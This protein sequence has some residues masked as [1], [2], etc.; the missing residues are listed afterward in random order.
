M[1]DKMVV[2]K[3][4]SQSSEANMLASLL[5][6]EGIECYVRDTIANQIFGDIDFVEVKIEL[7]EKDLPRA[8][9]IMK[10][11][12]YALS[13]NHPDNISVD[14]SEEEKTDAMAETDAMADDFEDMETA[15]AELIAYQKF[16]NRQVRMLS[17]I[18]ILLIIVGALIIILNNYYNGE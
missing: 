18:C 15:E 6:A 9:E 3:R 2:L 16:K 13:D 17:V 11:Y 12:G 7:L 1:E 10:A 8:I 14:G 5:Q 4:F